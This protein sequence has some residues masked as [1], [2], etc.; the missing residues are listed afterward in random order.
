MSTMEWI[1]IAALAG[2]L[3]FSTFAARQGW[4][5]TKDL[6]QTSSRTQSAT[7]TSRYYSGGK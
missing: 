6:S 5:G 2:G 4:G 3:G 1:L 7:H